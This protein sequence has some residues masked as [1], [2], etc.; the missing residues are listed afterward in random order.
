MM[1][2]RLDWYLLVFCGL[3][4]AP[5]TGQEH[6]EP[7]MEREHEEHANHAGL[8]LGAASHLHTD[9]TGIAVGLE[10]ARRLTHRV[11]LDVFAEYASS[12]LERDIIVGI[13][14]EV[15]PV[16][17]LALSAG[18]GIEFLSVEDE[19]TGTEEHETEFLL[20]LGAGYYLPLGRLTLRP[21]FNAD[22]AGGHWTLV[23]GA[24]LGIP[25]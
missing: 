15:V 24:A 3:L 17:G 21:T 18:P 16:G 20:R 23:Y 2:T 11:Y 6:G 9:E 14:L 19:E 7:G 1:N 25:F 10:Y 12:K 22:Y 4:A 13:P 5:L 8:F